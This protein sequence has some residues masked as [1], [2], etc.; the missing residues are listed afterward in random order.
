MSTVLIAALVAAGVSLA[1]AILGQWGAHRSTDLTLKAQRQQAHLEDERRLRDRRVDR[2]RAAYQST[3]ETLYG[4]QHWSTPQPDRFI[5]QLHAL[6]SLLARVALE[7]DVYLPRSASGQVLACLQQLQ[8]LVPANRNKPAIML[9]LL[10]LKNSGGIISS[11]DARWQKALHDLVAAM[12]AH[13]TD[14]E[15]PL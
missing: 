10:G 4:P 12:Q 8:Q 9:H 3:L 2:L 11:D 13:L 7:P 5:V 15:R 6:G 14:L 1:V